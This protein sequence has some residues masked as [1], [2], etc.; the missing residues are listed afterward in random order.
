[1][2]ADRTRTRHRWAY[3]VAPAVALVS[4]VLLSGL[5]AATPGIRPGLSPSGGP[6][7]FPW[8]SYPAGSVR[9][10]FPSTLPQVYL[11]D[12]ANA[13]MGAL[14]QVD[15]L[16]EL[17]SGGLP[18][19]TI[20]AAAYPTQAASFNSTPAENLSASPIAESASLEVHAV[21]AS[22]WSPSGVSTYPG[23][24]IGA[25]TLSFS[26]S[27]IAPPSSGVSV[28]WSVTGWPW[29]APTDLLALELHFGLTEASAVTPCAGT[30]S[31]T[32]GVGPAVCS[33]ASLS[34]HGI[35]WDPTIHSV[36]AQEPGGDSAALAWTP[37][38]TLAGG[39]GTSLVV[40]TFAPTNTSAEVV[41]GAS[42][43]G[44]PSV[45]GA[46]Q[47]S[48]FT[49]ALPMPPAVLRGSTLPYV[50]AVIAS[51]ALAG[52]GVLWYRRRDRRMRDSL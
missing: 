51:G 34:G 17:G 6:A 15:A 27:V 46:L 20:V 25:A 26:Y 37:T 2:D 13:S 29:V 39:S 47:F 11:V 38:A 42:A 7:Q 28:Q 24:A 45:S 32:T 33:G 5:A 41:L 16:L 50:A 35:A 31:G 8:A 30:G 48:L 19:P 23:R 52:L 1:M 14:L 49:P 3:R 36:V 43:G 9:I 12:A 22:L 10:V 44:S 21:S 18:H 40:G 4:I